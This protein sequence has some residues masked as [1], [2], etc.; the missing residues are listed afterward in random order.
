MQ[1]HSDAPASAPTPSADPGRLIRL[2]AVLARVGLG[3]SARLDLVREGRACR[4]VK[5]GRATLWVETEVR[6]FITDRIRQSRGGHVQP[7]PPLM[8]I[9]DADSMVAYDQQLLSTPSSVPSESERS[10]RAGDIQ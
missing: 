9:V 8:L 5:I 1:S 4:P 3:R 2:P 10:R 6:G 7:R